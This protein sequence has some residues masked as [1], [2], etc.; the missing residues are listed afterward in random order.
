MA[1]ASGTR[2]GRYEILLPADPAP[3]ATGIAETTVFDAW[4]PFRVLPRDRV[5]Y[6]RRSIDA[7]P[8]SA[9]RTGAPIAELRHLVGTNRFSSSTQL[10]TRT[11]LLVAA[12]AS[13]PVPSLI[14]RDRW[15]SG[16]I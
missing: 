8:L 3:T 2:L 10:R 6:D 1:L 15:P 13:A 12:A 14:M 7:W 9:P 5:L 16:A 11:R 4:I